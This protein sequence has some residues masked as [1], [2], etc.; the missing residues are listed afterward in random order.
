MWCNVLEATVEGM[1]MVA[2][3]LSHLITEHAH[4]AFRG[5]RLAFCF[6]LSLD[7]FSPVAR[8]NPG[9]APWPNHTGGSQAKDSCHTTPG[10]CSGLSINFLGR[11]SSQ[12]QTRNHPLIWQNDCTVLLISTPPSLMQLDWFHLEWFFCLQ[13]RAA[14]VQISLTPGELHELTSDPDLT[15]ATHGSDGWCFRTF[16]ISSLVGCLC[17][18]SERI[19]MPSVI[20]SV[21]HRPGFWISIS[22]I[23]WIKP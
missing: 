20:G 6:F 21:C 4:L 16:P 5:S 1:Q 11:L 8:E 13:H 14:G 3:W 19:P 23:S 10:G 15:T 22:S 17:S 7:G 12:G 9:W 2:K 18:L